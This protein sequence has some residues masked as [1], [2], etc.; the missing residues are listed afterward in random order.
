[1]EK[2]KLADID[3][4]ISFLLKRLVVDGEN[5]N[6][7]NVAIKNIYVHCSAT[8]GNPVVSCEFPSNEFLPEDQHL[9]NEKIENMNQLGVE[10]PSFTSNFVG[11]FPVPDEDAISHLIYTIKKV[12][13][14][15]YG[16]GA[17]DE[18]EIQISLQ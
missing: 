18:A 1:M 13:I 11:F 17:E 15:I 7:I 16:C 12:L 3:E 10:S 14:D 4:K 8:P 2:I 5:I 9:N 6:F